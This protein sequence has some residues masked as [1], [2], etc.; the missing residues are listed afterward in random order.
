M[1]VIRPVAHIWRTTSK[2]AVKFSHLFG[3]WTA[4][5]FIRFLF[6]PLEKWFRR[7][8]PL[9]VHLP[10]G[11][12]EN[13][14]P[15]SCLLWH[16]PAVL[17]SWYCLT[18]RNI[19]VCSDLPPQERV[20]HCCNVQILFS[21]E[22][23]LLQLCKADEPARKGCCSCRNDPTAARQMKNPFGTVIKIDVRL[24]ELDLKCYNGIQGGDGQDGTGNSSAD[25]K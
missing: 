15:L 3:V 14:C 19:K 5:F 4:S 10:A 24:A 25:S 13:K 11:W 22:K 20:S 17:K 18:R 16:V 12:Y 23:R 8:C 2:K 21:I 1:K 6:C 9:P 7:S